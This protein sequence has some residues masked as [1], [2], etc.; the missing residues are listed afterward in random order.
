MNFAGA[1]LRDARLMGADLRG[2]VGLSQAQIDSAH[3]DR[4]T[5]LPS[6]LKPHDQ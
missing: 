2:V 3:T 1:I 6:G 5:K 4:T